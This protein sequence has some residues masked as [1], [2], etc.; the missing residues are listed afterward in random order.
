MGL[1]PADAQTG[2]RHNSEKLKNVSFYRRMPQ[3]GD[4]AH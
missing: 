2:N 1:I 4:A 3:Q